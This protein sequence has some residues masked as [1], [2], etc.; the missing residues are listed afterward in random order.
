MAVVASVLGPLAEPVVPVVLFAAA[1]LVA[2]VVVVVALA[3]VVDHVIAAL[4]VSVT[5]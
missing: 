1:A 2:I 3:S 5:L 4:V